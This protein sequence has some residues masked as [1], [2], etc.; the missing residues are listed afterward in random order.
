MQVD[1]KKSERRQL[2]MNT[3]EKARALF[4]NS[5]GLLSTPVLNCLDVRKEEREAEAAIVEAEIA[6][7]L[8]AASAATAEMANT[9][10]IDTS[11]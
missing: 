3:V 11:I 8:A 7:A 10:N 2:R 4:Q 9:D 6:A 5:P 1:A